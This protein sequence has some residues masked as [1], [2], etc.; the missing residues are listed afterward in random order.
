MDD[1]LNDEA[2]TATTSMV[3]AA[4]VE[5]FCIFMHEAY[6]D[7]AVQQG[8][9]TQEASR[10]SWEDVPEAN[11]ETMRHTI[12]L[13]IPEVEKYLLEQVLE[14]VERERRWQNDQYRRATMLNTRLTHRYTRGRLVYIRNRIRHRL[15]LDPDATL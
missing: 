1:P 5:R 7:A 8:W 2:A 6:E 13:L 11:K 15:G 4:D 12:G 10:K 14:E 3:R 9:E